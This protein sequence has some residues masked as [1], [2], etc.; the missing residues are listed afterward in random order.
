M[1]PPCGPNT[2]YLILFILFTMAWGQTAELGYAA[3]LKRGPACRP[4]PWA[5]FPLI[6]AWFTNLARRRPCLLHL[7]AKLLQQLAGKAKAAAALTLQLML[8]VLASA[9]S[10][11][12]A[13]WNFA[14][15]VRSWK[16]GS[17]D[18]A[19]LMVR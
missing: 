5:N 18:N 17:H 8:S 1:P 13:N 19:K 10:A 12:S 16:E 2:I 6:S 9:A 4:N 15:R 7:V 14:Q 11:A 3:K